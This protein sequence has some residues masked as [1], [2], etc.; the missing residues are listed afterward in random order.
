MT[1]CKP[2]SIPINP[3]VANSLFSSKHQAD[4]ATIKWYQSAISL[5]MWP[6][7]HTRLKTSYLVGVLNRYCANPG[8]INCNLVIQIFQFLAGTLELKIT[9]KSNVT[10]ELVGYRDS[11]RAMFKDGQRS[12]GGYVFLLS[13]GPVS[14]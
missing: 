3:C 6:A 10:D 13:V 5:F 9:L 8:P 2:A 7:V 12:T 4:R 11:G 14:Y 1:D